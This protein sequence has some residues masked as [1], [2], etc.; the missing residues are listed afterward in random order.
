LRWTGSGMAGGWCQVAARP[1]TAGHRTTLLSHARGPGG[2]EWI[3][4]MMP[5][6]FRDPGVN[7]RDTGIWQALPVPGRPDP[8]EPRCGGTEGMAGDGLA[9]APWGCTWLSRSLLWQAGGSAPAA[10]RP[11]RD[12]QVQPTQ[13][14]WSDCFSLL[15]C[16]TVMQPRPVGQ[17]AP[18]QPGSSGQREEDNETNSCDRRLGRGRP[19][20]CR[21]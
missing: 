1:A 6:P 8:N 10:G 4:G 5:W 16:R 9:G 17:C 18:W 19:R 14:T 3:S 12:R 21:L 11:G 13:R 2:P 7:L 20:S 15:G